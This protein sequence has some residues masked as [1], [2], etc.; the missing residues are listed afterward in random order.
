[1]AIASLFSD[2]GKKN[3]EAQINAQQ[4]AHNRVQQ[5]EQQRKAVLAQYPLLERVNAADFN[6]LPPDEQAKVL[7]NA[8]GDVIKDIDWYH[9]SKHRQGQ[10]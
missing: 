4:A 3:F 6:K 9:A 5:L 7:Q 10:D 8:C 2:T 1:M